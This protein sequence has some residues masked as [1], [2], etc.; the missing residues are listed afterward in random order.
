MFLIFLI[1]K[2]EHLI[3]RRKIKATMLKKE[4][5]HWLV[6]IVPTCKKTEEREKNTDL[7]AES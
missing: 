2:A 4:P 1:L 3:I 5:G 7:K 6:I